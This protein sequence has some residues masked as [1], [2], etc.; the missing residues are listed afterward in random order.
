VG[1][2]LALK[3]VNVMDPAFGGDSQEHLYKIDLLAKQM[4]KENPL[5]WGRWDWNSY[6]GN[7]FLTGYNPLFYLLTSLIKI[8]SDLPIEII[9][10]VMVFTTYPLSVLVAYFLSYELSKHQFASLAGSIVFAN[11]NW[12]AVTVTSAGTLTHLLLFVLVPFTFLCIERYLRIQSLNSFFLATLVFSATLIAHFGFMLYLIPYLCLFLVV[13]FLQKRSSMVLRALLIIPLSLLVASFFLIPG[14]YYTGTFG[15]AFIRFNPRLS[16]VE[17]FMKNLV[18]L[19]SNDVGLLALLFQLIA[20]FIFVRQCRRT[21]FHKNDQYLPYLILFTLCM[22]WFF[23]SRLLAD[24]M[25]NTWIQGDLRLV[26]LFTS[27]V[28]SSYVVKRIHKGGE[29]EKV[30][31]LGKPKFQ[32]SHFLV[33]VAAVLLLVQPIPRWSPF[34]FYMVSDASE[35]VS[36]LAEKEVLPQFSD[37]FSEDMSE[38]WVSISGQWE[39]REDMCIG[40]KDVGEAYL[41]GKKEFDDFIYE[42]KFKWVSGNLFLGIVFRFL[43]ENNTYLL[44]W[45]REWNM[46][47]LDKVVDGSTYVIGRWDTTYPIQENTWHTLRVRAISDAFIVYVDS[48]YGFSTLDETFGRGKFGLT[49]LNGEAAFDDVRIQVFAD[50]DARDWSR[51]WLLPRTPA[52]TMVSRLTKLPTVDGWCDT[53]ANKQ[54]ISYLNLTYHKE[55]IDNTDLAIRGLRFLNVEYLFV[56]TKFTGN[57]PELWTMI[58]RE[59]HKSELVEVI[60]VN[61]AIEVIQIRNAHPIVASQSVFIIN[62]EDEIYSFYNVISNASFTPHQGILLFKNSDL[63][64]IE[65]GV[66]NWNLDFDDAVSVNVTLNEVRTEDMDMTFNVT[67]D[68]ECFVSLP[69]SYFEGLKV[70]VDSKG[71]RVLKALPAFI[72]FQLTAGTHLISVSRIITPLEISSLAVSTTTF[73]CL[74]TLLIID[75]TRRR[76]KRTLQNHTDHICHIKAHFFLNHSGE[77]VLDIGCGKGTY[78][79]FLHENGK[80]VIGLELDPRLSRIARNFGEVILGDVQ[81]LPFREACFDTALLGDLLEHLEDD[82]E[83]LKE[84]SRVLRGNLLLSVPRVEL[85]GHDPTHK[86]LY[87]Q[88]KLL[89]A[90]QASGLTCTKVQKWFPSPKRFLTVFAKAFAS[91][92]PAGFLA[93]ACKPLFVRNRTSFF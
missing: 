93:E 21:F 17:V 6:C 46:L 80:D 82:V 2:A 56:D 4:G 27:P 40:R 49:V 84:T 8:V 58:L 76:K 42:T 39:V 34:R 77:R 48:N 53:I 57:N 52:Q 38:E 28:L 79:K 15:G 16:G 5:L 3:V 61:P 12:L 35:F 55:L 66:W 18:Y 81:H 31:R 89:S 83:A 32:T 45:K 1:L 26:S 85:R 10:N 36:N 72:S 59:L 92:Y 9:I 65:Y 90:I 91:I 60:Y 69:I 11:L 74:I 30:A 29:R 62:T 7:L 75:F 22:L 25:N 63:T 73:F 51:I 44:R 50:K 41:L 47:E 19:V 71:A 87:S 78:L 33:V 20:V 24:F 37:D 86:R 43:D 88:E 23:P 70:E 54:I 67:V 68:R 13:K 64:G 14:L